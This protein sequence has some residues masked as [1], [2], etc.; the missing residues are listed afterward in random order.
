M[1]L[2]GMHFSFGFFLGSNVGVLLGTPPLTGT[3]GGTAGGVDFLNIFTR[4]HNAYLCA[5]TALAS[6]IAG[7]IFY[8]A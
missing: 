4:D 8:S 7:S 6:G 1:A 3:L 2:I 5:F